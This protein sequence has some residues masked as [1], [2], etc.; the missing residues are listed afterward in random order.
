[1]C[2]GAAS[3][4][5]G[6]DAVYEYEIMQPMDIVH[7]ELSNYARCAE[8]CFRDELVRGVCA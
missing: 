1:V 2:G 3:G 5:A 7:V 8:S 4:R 6:F